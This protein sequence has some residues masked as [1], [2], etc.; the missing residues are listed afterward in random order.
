[1]HKWQKVDRVKLNTVHLIREHALKSLGSTIH[2]Q[3]S[4]HYFKDCQKPRGNVSHAENYFTSQKIFMM[5]FVRRYFSHVFKVS[6]VTSM[7]TAC[8]QCCVCVYTELAGVWLVSMVVWWP[9]PVP[10]VC[11]IPPVHTMDTSS[12]SDN[13]RQHCRGHTNNIP[14]PRPSIANILIVLSKE[15]NMSEL[16]CT[17]TKICLGPFDNRWCNNSPVN[18]A[19]TIDGWVYLLLISAKVLPRLRTK[20][21]CWLFALI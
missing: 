15:N 11:S 3:P 9:Q 17:K 14:Q 20:Q 4:I 6:W 7:I 16:V 18:V 21:D 19:N 10:V 8:D 5:G 12:G 1:M 13:T 2:R